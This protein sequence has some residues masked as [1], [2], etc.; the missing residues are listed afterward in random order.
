VETAIIPTTWR[1]GGIALLGGTPS[2]FNWN[3]GV[4]TGF[5]LSKWDST[6]SEGRESP[7]GSIHQELQLARARDLSVYAAASYQGVPGLT[8]GGGVFTGKAGQGAPN[9]AAPDARVTLWEGHARWQ[10][11]PF[12]LSALYARGTISDTQALNLTFVGDPTPVPESFWG[13]YV[14]G[15][16]HAWA[17]KDYSLTPF[18]RY[19]WVNTAA[20]YEPMPEGLGVPP[21]PTERVGTIGLNFNIGP[22]VVLKADYQK[23]HVDSSRDRFDLGFGYSF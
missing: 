12:D 9:F 13:A 5:D 22:N 1:E 4:T 8:V 3:V 19:E 20:S 11:G 14:Q 18:A 23:F 21:S 7:L 15:A 17:Y 2:G 16:W 10:T 6:S